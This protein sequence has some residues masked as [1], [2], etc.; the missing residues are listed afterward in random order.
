MTATIQVWDRVDCPT[1][2][3][4]EAYLQA[5]GWVVAWNLPPGRLWS[6][7]GHLVEVPDA[8]RRDW[9]RCARDAIECIAEIEGRT[10]RAVAL[11]MLAA[12]TTRDTP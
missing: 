2:A 11:E 12:P 4:V 9:P 5:H 3:Q 6:R 7:A 1:L 10:P 8:E